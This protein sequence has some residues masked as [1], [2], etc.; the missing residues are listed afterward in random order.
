MR[1]DTKFKIS[2]ISIQKHDNKT[3]YGIIHYNKITKQFSMIK[4]VQFKKI[5]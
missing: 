2:P 4:N 3:I 1:V 5:P